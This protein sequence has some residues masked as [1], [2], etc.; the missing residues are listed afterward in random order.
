MSSIPKEKDE[1]KVLYAAATLAQGKGGRAEAEKT[2]L[3]LRGA[4][5]RDKL[6][7]PPIGERSRMDRGSSP[8]RVKRTRKT[9]VIRLHP[10]DKR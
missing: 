6:L 2:E 1:L 9:H 10:N 5:K 3:L 8:R 4:N 7:T